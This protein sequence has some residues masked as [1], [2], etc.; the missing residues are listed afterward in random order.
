M[1][2]HLALLLALILM[3]GS[4]LPALAETAEIAAEASGSVV[5]AE[6]VEEQS[7]AETAP[8]IPETAETS[9]TDFTGSAFVTEE[10]SGSAGDDS[11][12]YV[13]GELIVCVRGGREA[14]EADLQNAP[15]LLKSSEE[16]GDSAGGPGFLPLYTL[17]PETAG[18]TD[19]VGEDIPVEAS[20]EELLGAGGF[21][22]A[23]TEIIVVK[24]DESADLFALKKQYEE[25]PH[26]E[27]A[28]LNY[29]HRIP[30]IS[31]TD[32]SIAAAAEQITDTLAGTAPGSDL[33]RFFVRT[34]SD[35]WK[36]QWAVNGT[37]RFGM[38]YYDEASPPYSPVWTDP[39]INQNVNP[40]VSSD[41][42]TPMD[43]IVVALMD[44]GIEYNNPVMKDSL[45]Y[46]PESVR[47][48]IKA[49]YGLDCG[50][51][52]FSAAAY[53][54]GKENCEDPLD[55]VGHGTHCAGIMA[56]S[57][58]SG[59]YGVANNA[60]ILT[61]GLA[62]DDGGLPDTAI[63]AGYYFLKC[64]V[65]EGVNVVA[66][67]NSW[68]GNYSGYAI[69]RA[70]T[71]LGE[72]G[73]LSVFAAG[74]EAVDLDHYSDTGACFQNNPYVIVANAHDQSGMPAFFTN[75]GLKTTDVS[76]P[77]VAIISAAA[78]VNMMMEPS[79]PDL[80]LPLEDSSGD[81]YYAGFST[82]LM[83]PPV[84]LDGAFVIEQTFG[85]GMTVATPSAPA[86]TS[87]RTD[88]LNL[89]PAQR[90]IPGYGPGYD[91]GIVVQMPAPEFEKQSG[92]IIGFNVSMA[93]ATG[94]ESY[95]IEVSEIHGK[96]LI[97]VGTYRKTPGSNNT[98][99]FG[100]HLPQR[101]GVDGY[102]FRFMLL[103]DTEEG[104]KAV[105][106]GI[107]YVDDILVTEYGQAYIGMNGT[108]MAAPYVTGEA[109]VLAS[110]FAR[111]ADFDENG[112]S[113]R[114]EEIK[115]RILGGTVPFPAYADRDLNRTGGC[116]NLYQAVNAAETGT[117]DPVLMSAEYA[118]KKV[119]VTGYFLKAAE[120]CRIRMDGLEIPLKDVKWE[121]D[122]NGLKGKFTFPA[123]KLVTGEHEI[124][125][126]YGNYD[127]YSGEGIY[128]RGFF[129]LEA[130][131]APEYRMEEI[132]LPGTDDEFFDDS[133]ESL[134]SL[135]GKL[136]LLSEKIG[137]DE[138]DIII[139]IW[140]YDPAAKGPWKK[141]STISG[142][143]YGSEFS[144]VSRLMAY[145]GKL[146]IFAEFQNPAGKYTTYLVTVDP[147]DS[148]K[149][150]MKP[151]EGEYRGD[152]RQTQL[153]AA[154][155]GERL[156]TYGYD[157]KNDMG[158]F[159]IY[160]TDD[161]GSFKVVKIWN[162][163]GV[164]LGGYMRYSENG[165]ILF[166]GSV[167][168]DGRGENGL[169]TVTVNEEKAEL[170]L[171]RED[172]IFPV[173]G[174]D[175]EQ[176]FDYD[177]AVIKNGII[178]VGIRDLKGHDTY[179]L[180]GLTADAGISTI[181]YYASPTQMFNV[182]TVAA[183]GKLY[184]LGDTRSSA[185]GR[186]L[187]ASL[188]LSLIGKE[189]VPN[190]GD[191]E[192]APTPTP[193][194][195]PTPGGGGSGGGSSSG[196]PKAASKPTFSSY[197]YTDELGRWMIKDKTGR[198]VAN[199]WLCDDAV[200][201]NGKNI[202]YILNADGTMQSAGLLRDKSGNYFSL[203]TNHNGYFGMMRYQD[204]WY[205]CNGKP[206]YLQFN[207]DHNGA[208][209]AIINPEGIVA[210]RGIYGETYFNVGNDTLVYTSNF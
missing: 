130:E 79:H 175:P 152:T 83:Q 186:R 187:F 205:T 190:P 58:G 188:D 25:L 45:W 131:S 26:V 35:V 47:E 36:Q 133:M 122:G 177:I 101:P 67:N 196:G 158:T 87:I 200:A 12:S 19:P 51:Y 111:T 86:P 156:I 105:D 70:V 195:T 99:E 194:P 42:E 22:T 84:I 161:A 126:Q 107:I 178:T 46:C 108:S 39:S 82:A 52:G 167:I 81:R 94:S 198:P 120:D 157:G 76:A 174:I 62:T 137:Q 164:Q 4:V 11:L 118:D 185:S 148:Y 33:S 210:L 142:M 180:E 96:N 72:L 93:N 74:N 55:V 171:L 63:L 113:A 191:K 73:V 56:A 124:E 40:G 144:G 9:G 104:T 13:P 165:T 85:R 135:N 116:A 6:A 43:A 206:V 1:K 71:D 136:Y 57:W 54:Q 18:K 34:P 31:G 201:G 53:V 183:D 168:R 146:V 32:G 207:K 160:R 28:E 97:T 149:M 143:E 166:Y 48:N 91:A 169:F 181:P 30:E 150:E 29:I 38:G 102:G 123:E 140:E 77:G 89:Y 7:A 115:A 21:E 145:Q 199:A 112:R 204:G 95:A 15:A 75:R 14:L 147:A 139:T 172:V 179:C 189:T 103:K 128:G 125:I 162:K 106:P 208:F 60:K 114:A 50:R 159:R 37:S 44:S 17:E 16:S 202:W 151:V 98:L 27:S 109:A 92:G 170:T 153:Y 61:V 90:V 64:A 110:Y 80:F 24:V 88:C 100:L 121:F 134:C 163:P 203:E 129:M 154:T 155:D 41:T 23:V 209:G 141:V 5:A 2:R 66:A 20:E 176:A 69:E 49:K 78:G 59:I 182:F 132:P 138:R 192:P 117:Y 68:G 197:W 8:E 173:D 127:K 184:V 193:T 65:K 119:T 10:I 3:A